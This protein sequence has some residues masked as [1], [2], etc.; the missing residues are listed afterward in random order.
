LKSSPFDVQRIVVLAALPQTVVGRKTLP[1]QTLPTA[2]G[3][4]NVKRTTLGTALLLAVVG[5]SWNVIGT[6]ECLA[7]AA[8]VLTTHF[9]LSGSGRSV[10]LGLLS[11]RIALLW[12]DWFIVDFWISAGLLLCRQLLLLR[13]GV[14]LLKG[15]LRSPPEKSDPAPS[16]RGQ[17]LAGSGLLVVTL[18]GIGG[19]RGAKFQCV[20]CSVSARNCSFHPALCLFPLRLSV[21]G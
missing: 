19:R 16:V 13:I 4:Q 18:G 21:E 9:V 5:A 12:V 20:N 6:A 10:C 15:L 7:T 1:L 17:L 8:L 2:L 14:L 11:I 3:L